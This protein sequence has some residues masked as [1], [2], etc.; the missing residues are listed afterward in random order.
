LKEGRS[1][2]RRLAAG[3]KLQIVTAHRAPGRRMWRCRG[4][5]QHECPQSTGSCSGT[6]S[7]TTVQPCQHAP[8]DDLL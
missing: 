5:E 8:R 4:P 6:P 3:L 1:K 2:A 7:M